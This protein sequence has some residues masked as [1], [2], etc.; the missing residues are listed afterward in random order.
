[1][2][3]HTPGPWEYDKTGK[4]YTGKVVRMNGHL[5]AKMC[6]S[7]T[8]RPGETDACAALIAAAPELLLACQFAAQWYSDN[9]DIMPVAFQTVASEL[10]RVIAKATEGRE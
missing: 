6:E 9:I 10:E 4:Y 7:T 3:K 1:M 2:S 5:I 8:H